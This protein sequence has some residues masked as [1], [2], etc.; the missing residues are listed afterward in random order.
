MTQSLPR[1]RLTAVVEMLLRSTHDPKT[2]HFAAR[3]G[4]FA[5]A[6]AVVF[7]AAAAVVFWVLWRNSSKVA[8]GYSSW[9]MITILVVAYT[10][11][12]LQ[13]WVS[14]Q[15]R[16]LF[17][18]ALVLLVLDQALFAAVSFLTGG[19][20]SGA[21]SLF[22]VTC[23]VGGLLLGMPGA[24]TAALSG[25]VFFNVLVLIT[26]G[27]N[28]FYP[29][30]Q[31]AELYSLTTG[32]AAY[33]YV[34]NVLMLLLV[35]LLTSYLAER[36][37]RAGGQLEEAQIRV[38][39]AERMAELGRLAAGLAHEIRN[40]LGAISGSIQMLKTEARSDDDR[41]LCDIVLRES[42]RLNDLVSDMLDL[43]RPRP[44]QRTQTDLGRIV[45]EVLDLARRSGRGFQDVG[46]ERLGLQTLMVEVDGAQI[47]QLVW[48][49]VR[50]AVQATASGGVV[51][52]K[53]ENEGGPSLSVEDDGPGIDSEAKE[54]LFDAFFTTR[55]QGTGLGLAVVKRI[56]DDHGFKVRVHSEDGGGAVFCVE[57]SPS[58]ERARRPGP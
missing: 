53:L 14:T 42:N 43:A 52:V 8:F 50:N 32:Q 11:A 33:Y 34:F 12:F 39:R 48:N 45:H 29:P 1:R 30:D 51:R 57:F 41:E 16:R 31:S 6:R 54:Q 7:S 46:I 55:S 28:P 25:A 26:Q 36:L 5:V 24:L 10:S 20:S 22:G 27:A 15:R 2:G 49:L 19:V 4:S 47:R 56:A 44:P 9:A 18:V 3:L 17:A 37:Q 35:G 23:L 21:T 58:E 40:P 38:E 13:Y